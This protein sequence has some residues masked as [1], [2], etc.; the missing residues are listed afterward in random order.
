ME[1]NIATI[2]YLFFRLAPFIIVCFF[3]LQS[4]FN[5]DLKGLVRYSEQKHEPKCRTVHYSDQHLTFL[6]LKLIDS[7]LVSLAGST[8]GAFMNDVTKVGR[9]VNTFVMLC[10]RV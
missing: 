4:I 2:I 9:G 8:C 1:L 10:L 6:L 3:S 7:G 5:Q